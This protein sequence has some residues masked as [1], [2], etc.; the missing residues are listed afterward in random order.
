MGVRNKNEP[1]GDESEENEEGGEEESDCEER[2]LFELISEHIDEFI[3]I[4]R[5]DHEIRYR[6][7]FD[8]RICGTKSIMC[9]YVA[10]R[11][12]TAAL[13]Q[14]KQ[15]ESSRSREGSRSNSDEALAWKLAILDYETV[16][17][18]ATE[19]RG[20]RSRPQKSLTTKGTN[21]RS[22]SLP[23]SLSSSRRASTVP[24]PPPR[25]PPKTEPKKK[26]AEYT[27]LP[28]SAYFRNHQTNLVASESQRSSKPKVDFHLSHEDKE[29]R[30][31]KLL[32]KSDQIVSRLAQL[33]PSPPPSASASDS[34]Q[35]GDQMIVEPSSTLPQSVVVE[36]TDS[37]TNTL[38]SDSNEISVRP[39]TP[40]SHSGDHSNSSSLVIQYPLLQGCT[41]RNYQSAGVEWLC[42]LHDAG[43][44]G[45]LADEMGLGQLILISS[46]HGIL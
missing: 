12:K 39:I 21:S 18:T 42:G 34:T 37:E 33:I 25:P 41:L 10:R 19:R 35:S 46:S 30:L 44:N 22:N 2:M 14:L 26:K 1:E 32:Q 15:K 29:T 6:C 4:I 17:S 45:I 5:Q 7:N 38:K 16:T 27:P 23:S 24:G 11:H 40:V 8:G 36:Q 3:E 13:E 31:K 28:P 20:T 43:L 9:A